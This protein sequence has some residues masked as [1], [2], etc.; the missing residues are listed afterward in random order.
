MSDPSISRPRLPRER[1]WGPDPLEGSKLR[2]LWLDTPDRPAPRLPLTDD[3]EVDL[4]VVGGGFT[5]LWTALRAVER[6]PGRRVVLIEGDRIAEH[7]TGRNGGL[8][9]AS[10]THG[11]HNGRARWPEEYDR[12]DEIGMRNLDDIEQT[13]GRYGIA[14]GFRRGGSLSVATRS[15]EVLRLRPDR[16]GFLDATTTRSIVDSPTYLA[17][18]YSRDDCAVVDPARLAWGLADTA[19]AH[20]VRI[21][22]HTRLDSLRYKGGRVRATTAGGT[23]HA[24]NVVLATNVFP[25]PLNRPRWSVVPVYDYVLATEPLTDEQLRSLNWD[26]AIGVTDSGNQFHYYRITP[27]RRVLWGGYDAVYHFGRFIRS[28]LQDRRTTFEKLAQHFADTFPQ[29][30]G[31]R[32][33]HRWAGVIDTST[34]FAAFFGRAHRGRTAYATGFTGLGVGASRF[35]AD[36]MLD[37]LAGLDTERT[38]L[39]MVREKPMPFPPEPIT[40]LGIRITRWSLER[41]DRTGRRNVWL[42]LLDRLGLGFDS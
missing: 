12:L 36:V 34:R 1:G 26:P 28:E 30:E 3:I 25:G 13:V 20:G 4:L 42:R 35:A 22:E 17:G 2:P 29:L 39:R 27:D 23:V 7:A 19:E 40:W 38:R 21:Y 33:T 16:E 14:C 18:R 15:H 31:I 9:E 8:C 11:E 32:F 24:A 41:E 6:D 37:Q 10:I 5:G